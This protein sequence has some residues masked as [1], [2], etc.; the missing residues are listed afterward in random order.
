M[1]FLDTNVLL[2]RISN[3]PAEKEKARVAE[4]ILRQTDLGLSV[5]VLQEFY[6]QATRANRTGALTHREA[7]DLVRAWQR[8]P[9]QEITVPVMERAMEARDQWGISYWDAAVIEAARELGCH[10]ILSEDLSR[11]QNY[12]GIRIHNPFR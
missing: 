11:G 2:Y 3:D 6:T 5:Q 4:E 9:V 10:E 12:R 8:Y 1:R 7:L